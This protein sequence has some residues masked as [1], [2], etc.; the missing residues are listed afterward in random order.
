MKKSILFLFVMFT[1]P[2][3]GQQ[4]KNVTDSVFTQ[5]T[6]Q[7]ETILSS[8]TTKAMTTI[9]IQNE[10][11]VGPKTYTGDIIKVGS[12]VTSSKIKGPVNFKSGA[13]TL[14]GS[15]ITFYPQTTMSKDSKVNL[16]I[17]K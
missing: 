7:P 16:T 4:T 9:Y 10:T 5:K 11:I 17:K 8:A 3:W 2:I 14:T 6:Q 1:P 13:I 12:N 15:E